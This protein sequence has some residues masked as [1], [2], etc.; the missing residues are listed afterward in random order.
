MGGYQKDFAENLGLLSE[1]NTKTG[2]NLGSKF[3]NWGVFIDFRFISCFIFSMK[4]L[5]MEHSKPLEYFIQACPSTARQTAT[6][7]LIEKPYPYENSIQINMVSQ[8]EA[9]IK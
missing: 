7:E 8:Q 1:M 9:D 4:R 6:F 3:L 5:Q 2:L